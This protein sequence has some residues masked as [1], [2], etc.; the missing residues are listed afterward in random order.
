VFEFLIEY[1]VFFAI[2]VLAAHIVLD[3]FA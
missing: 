3:L 1:S 2:P